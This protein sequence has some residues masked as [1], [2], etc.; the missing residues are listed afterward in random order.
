MSHTPVD[1]FL[2]A[3]YVWT[4]KVKGHKVRKVLQHLFS[5]LL[6]CDVWVST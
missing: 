1:F 6:G 5:E 3:Q 4:E 2:L